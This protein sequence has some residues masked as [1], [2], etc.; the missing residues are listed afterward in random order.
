MIRLSEHL[1][2]LTD[3]ERSFILDIAENGH[4]E[5]RII[6]LSNIEKPPALPVNLRALKMVKIYPAHWAKYGQRWGIKLE[7]S[8]L[9]NL[10]PY[11]NGLR[12]YR[13]EI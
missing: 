12:F 9:L 11:R 2:A 3:H 8:A 4:F 7:L 6:L 13:V 10:Q 1:F 5:A